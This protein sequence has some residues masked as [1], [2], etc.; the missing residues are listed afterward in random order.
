VFGIEAAE[1]KTMPSSR[2]IP[3]QD[4]SPRQIRLLVAEDNA[5]LRDYLVT[6]LRAEGYEVAEASTADDLVDTLAVSLHPDLGSGAFDLVI[7]EDRLVHR[8]EASLS[9]GGWVR[10][11]IPPFVLIG[12]GP[13]REPPHRLE[14]KAVARLSKPLD[15]EDLCSTVRTLAETASE[16]PE[17]RAAAG[18][19]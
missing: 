19:N 12:A 17:P 3:V 9:W 15:M 8:G 1:Q 7:A 2:E 4:I 11:K 10:A 13:G 14:P 5:A 16:M 6:V 18:N